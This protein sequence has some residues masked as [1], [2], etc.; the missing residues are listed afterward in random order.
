MICV[1]KNVKI[2]NI[3]I[4]AGLGQTK[5]YMDAEINIEVDAEILIED[6]AVFDRTMHLYD[7]FNNCIFYVSTG[8]SGINE[9]QVRVIIKCLVPNPCQY[10]T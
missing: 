9:K 2:N 4:H 6:D 7:E 5:L 1:M 8:D 3:S 10:I